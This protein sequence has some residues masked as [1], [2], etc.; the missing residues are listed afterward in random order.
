MDKTGLAGKAGLL[1]KAGA[2]HALFALQNHSMTWLQV[3]I[4]L[5]VT[6]AVAMGLYLL[7][8]RARNRKS[9]SVHV[10]RHA[11]FGALNPPLVALVWLVG[12]SVAVATLVAGHQLPILATVYPPARNVIAIIIV[13]WFLVRLAHRVTANWAAHAAAKGKEF[14][15]TA[16]DAINKLST[17]LIVVIAFMIIMQ[18][19]GF[20]IASLLAFGGVAGI[21]IGFAAQ[22]LVANLLGGI[23]IYVS[24]PFKVGEYIIFPSSE[25]MGEVEYIGWRATRVLGFNGKPF[26]VPNSVFNNQTII[27]HSRLEYRTISEH[28]CIR[29]EDIGKVPAIV[30]DANAMLAEHPEMNHARSFYVFRFDSYG[31]FALKLLLYAYTKSKGYAD[32]MAAKNDILLKIADIIAEHDAQLAVPVSSV[33][34]PEGLQLHREHGPETAGLGDSPT[35]G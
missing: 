24:R 10:W 25:L 8:R 23:T 20:S 35:A 12:I 26:Y 21:A 4:I 19:L 28:I 32:F 29:L 34:L 11:I 13:A 18:R 27:N 7:V 2:D 16:A 9:R 30:N 33:R 14:D 6:L 1:G 22:G 31:D 17:A 15:G 5:G 3:L